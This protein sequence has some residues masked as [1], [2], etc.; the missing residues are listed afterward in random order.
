MA[1]SITVRGLDEAVRELDDMAGR[2][3]DLSPVMAVIAEDIKTFVDDRFRSSTDPTGARWQPLAEATKKKRRQGSGKI[4]VDTGVL[5]NSVNA[6]PGPR[7]VRFGTNVPYAAT[8]Q[9]GSGKV[10]RRGFLPINEDG[11]SFETKG[12]AGE[13]REDIAELIVE[14]LK[15]GQ[16]G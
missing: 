7:S 2:L 5:R 10:P 8:H 11:D 6:R 13:L 16:V 9:F 4:L 1:T 3:H 12:P 15:T 14:Y